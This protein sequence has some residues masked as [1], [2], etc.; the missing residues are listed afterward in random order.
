MPL[1]A[2]MVDIVSGLL[3]ALFS[4]AVFALSLAL[5]EGASGIAG[6]GFL[7]RV[8][9]TFGVVLGLML[10]V[11][12]A[13]A[14]RGGSSSKGPRTRGWE[15][16]LR[17]LALVVVASA[18]VFTLE[19]YGFLLTSAG[20]LFMTLLILGERRIAMLVVIPVGFTAGVYFLFSELLGLRLPSGPLL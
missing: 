6:P 15:Y 20:F 16:Y 17:L 2:I 12:G 14:I 3:F 1:R 7:P 10:C 8:L 19:P 18:Y 5:P 11:R 9:G 13:Y 4:G